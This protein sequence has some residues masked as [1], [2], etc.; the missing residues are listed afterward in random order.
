MQYDSVMISYKNPPSHTLP[1]GQYR[2]TGSSLYVLGVFFM[3]EIMLTNGGCAMVDD[4]N[5]NYL[6]QWKWFRSPNGYAISTIGLIKMHR[7]ITGAKKGE[8][9]DH[10]DHD[11]LNNTKLNLRIVS[12]QKN[13]HN[14]NKRANTK[15]NFKGVCFKPRHGLWESRCRMFGK[16]HELGLYKSEIA[17]AYAY[18]KKAQELSDCILINKLNLPVDVLEDMIINDKV[19]YKRAV[20]QSTQKGV[21]W[22]SGHRKWVVIFRKCNQTTRLGEYADE[23]TAISVAKEYIRITSTQ[24]AVKMAKHEFF[25]RP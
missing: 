22:H 10:I 9:V 21:F 11:T 8:L 17:A 23:D 19:T 15:N 20:K 6:T 18:N 13:V 14:Q 4:E 16:N 5:Y 25:K 7:L 24:N 12:T 3:K 2:L 1:L